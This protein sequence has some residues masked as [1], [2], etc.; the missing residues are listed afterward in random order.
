MKYYKFTKTITVCGEIEAESKEIAEK[1]V[2]LMDLAEAI[3]NYVASPEFI[4]L[5]YDRFGDELGEIVPFF[6]Y[7]G[8]ECKVM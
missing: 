3:D 6:D 4:D 7:E 5:A 1:V 8:I 2:K